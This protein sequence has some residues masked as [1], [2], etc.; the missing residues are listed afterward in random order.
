MQIE[1]IGNDLKNIMEMKLYI[2]CSIIVI[3]TQ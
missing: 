1:P 3:Y 2:N